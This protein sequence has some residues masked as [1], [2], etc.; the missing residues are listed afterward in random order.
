M[1]APVIRIAGFRKTFFVGLRRKP[2]AAAKDISFDVHAGEIFGFLGPNGAGKTTSIKALL[3][4]IRPDGGELAILGHA[5][6]SMEWRRSVGYLPEHPTFYDYLTGFE[7][8]TWF[9]QLGGMVRAEAERA[10]AKQ[11]ERVKLGHAMHRRLRSYSKGMLQRA[12]LAQA[13]VADPKLLIL[14]EPMTGLD[15]IGRKD[16][17]E[18]LMELRASGKSIFYSTHILPD[19]EATCDRVAIVHQGSTQR[20]GRLE[21]ILGTATVSVSLRMTGLPP[22]SIDAL[23]A[24][25][26]VTGRGDGW[27]ELELPDLKSAQALGARAASEGGIIDALIPHREDLESLFVRTLGT[28]QSHPQESSS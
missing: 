1:S 5:P 18:I 13:L 12:G 23:A 8:V 16:I 7:L 4:L 21:D 9:G 11:L 26:R 6:R 19:V 3:D 2:F 28:T 17:R 25:Q 20:V 24:G 22:L 14:D 15:P 10:A 27:L